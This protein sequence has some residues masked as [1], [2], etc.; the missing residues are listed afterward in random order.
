MPPS[1]RSYRISSCFNEG[2]SIF[3]QQIH[4]TVVPSP[5]DVVLA[6]I[7][8]ISELGINVIILDYQRLPGFIG[9]NELSKRRVYKMASVFKQNDIVPLLVIRCENQYVDLSN[10]SLDTIGDEVIR[11]EQNFRIIKI[12]QKWL[13]RCQNEGKEDKRFAMVEDEELWSRVMESTLWL[14]GVGETFDR[15][16][17]I[18]SREKTIAESF[19]ALDAFTADPDFELLRRTIFESI[20]YEA[21][22]KISLQVQCFA[23]NASAAIRDLVKTIQS[24]LETEGTQCHLTI[25][26]PLYEF[27]ISG[28]RREQIY[29]LE[30][31]KLHL[32][33]EKI[34]SLPDMDVS[35]KAEFN[36]VFLHDASS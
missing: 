27:R 15:L 26:A 8:S 34:S 28:P 12:F 24:Q 6:K 19:P 23:V 11:M 18:A 30:K 5:D 7:D 16:K 13:I 14:H 29:S 9:L 22:M 20:P 25:T 33:S 21:I 10:K 4:R 32:I 1:C 2:S 36:D 35:I 17:T 31:T 3:R